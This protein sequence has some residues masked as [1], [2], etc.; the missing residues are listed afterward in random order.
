ML[1]AN[2]RREVRVDGSSET[3][4]EE[5]RGCHHA[6]AEVDGLHHA[7]GG[8]NAQHCVEVGV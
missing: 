3:I 1:P 4:V 5:L 2:W 8:E 7:P 6:R